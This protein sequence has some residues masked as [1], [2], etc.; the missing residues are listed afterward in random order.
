MCVSSGKVVSYISI[1][2]ADAKNWP[3]DP[4]N[5]VWPFFYSIFISKCT[6]DLT[7]YVGQTVKEQKKS[8][9]LCNSRPLPISQMKFKNETTRLERRN[10][11]R[12]SLLM[13]DVTKKFLAR[14]GFAQKWGKI[15]LEK[16]FSYIFLHLPTFLICTIF[17][18]YYFAKQPQRCMEIR[19][20]L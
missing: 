8:E 4:V 1:T 12:L 19:I 5:A 16:Y 11:S 10:G 17:L 18:I 3:S 14:S 13:R 15:I 9:L 6:K 7:K 2:L 20:L